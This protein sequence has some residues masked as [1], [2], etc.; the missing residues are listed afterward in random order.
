MKTRLNIEQLKSKLPSFYGVIAEDL[1]ATEEYIRE[2]LHSENKE[3]EESAL[4]LLDSGGKRLRPGLLLLSGY[5][6]SYNREKLI[7]MAAA[8]EMIHMASLVHDDIVDG[9]PLRRGKPTIAKAKGDETALLTG[10]FMLSKAMGAV[11]SMGDER[12][13][14]IAA[15]TAT[16]MCRGEF[17]QLEVMESPDFSTEHYIRRIRRKT[18]NLIA[19]A[20]EIGAYICGAEES[21]VTAMREFGKNIGIAFQIT[22]DILD[23]TGK[24]TAFGKAVGSDLAEGLTT[25]P[26]ICAWQNGNQK[27]VIQKLFTKSRTSRKAVTELISVVEENNGTQ[28]AADLAKNYIQKAKTCLERIEN[29]EIRAGFGEIA[30]FIL[31]REH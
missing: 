24:N 16:E 9:T 22:D 15:D 1:L 2:L 31:T 21:A 18:A 25:M 8:V 6:G 5:C 17:L 30:D 3:I 23:Y 4:Y 11:L 19:A 20:A 13:R 14:K 27:E 26:L 12:I 28:A 7:P 29:E 10:N